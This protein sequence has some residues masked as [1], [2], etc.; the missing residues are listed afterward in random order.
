MTQTNK[1]KKGIHS[2][3]SGENLILISNPSADPE[4]PNMY[5]RASSFTRQ[6]N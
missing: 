1:N 3:Y 2:F 5:Q 6:F 4:H